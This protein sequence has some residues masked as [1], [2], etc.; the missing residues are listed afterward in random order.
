VTKSPGSNPEDQRRVVTGVPVRDRSGLPADLPPGDETEKPVSRFVSRRTILKAV[1]LSA[2]IAFNP[3]RTALAAAAAGP[4]LNI[5]AHEDDDLLF[6]SPDLLHA[7]QGGGKVRTIFVTAGD[8]GSGTSYWTGRQNGM[9]AA[10][11]Q[12]AGVSNSWTQADAGIAGHPMPLYT[13]S[14]ASAV[15]LIFMH[16]PDG[17]VDGGGFSSNNDE[18]LQELWQG[19]ISTI[20]AIDGSSSYTKA[21]LTSTLTA[22][23]SAFGAASVNTQD[24]VGTFG[25]GDHSDHHAAAYFAQA[26]QQAYG[27]SSVLAGYLDYGTVDKPANVTGAD[28]TAK[29]NA[30]Y[31]YAPYDTDQC[32]TPSACAG[33]DYPDWLQRQYLVT[34]STA[35]VA[36]AGSNQTVQPGATVTLNGSGSSDPNRKTLTYQ[37]TQTGGTAVTL[38]SSTAVQPTFTAPSSPGTLTFQLVVSNGTSSSSPATVAI[39]VGTTS[40]DL[41]LTAKATASSAASGQAAAKAIDGV[42]SGYPADSSKEWATNGGKAGSWLKLTWTTAQTIDTIVLY[43]RPNTSDQ[44]TGGNIAFSDG[45]SVAVGSLPNDGSAY[46]LTFAAKTVTTLQLNIT[47]VSSTTENVGLAEIQVYRTGSSGGSQPPVAN[48]GSN[49]TVQTGA[50]VTLNGTGSSDPGGKSLTYQ[51]TQTGGAAVTLS[52]STAAQPTFTA[53]SSA[54]TLTF[55]LVVNNGT[56]SSSP[57]TVTITVST[58]APSDLALTAKATASSAAS[59]QGAAKA[60]DGVISGYPADSSK[61]W[62]SNGGKAGSWL[63]LT[64][65]TAQTFNTIVLYDRPNTNDQITGGNI[66]FSDGTSIAVGSLPNAGTAYT[67]TF[68][69]KTVTTLQLNITSV[70]STTE[71]VGLSEI[72]VYFR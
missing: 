33:S 40:P 47:S 15:S 7:I 19:S 23:M 61:E 52:S 25:D 20:H 53:P 48:A 21:T 38:S 1:P 2:L 56:A 6:L 32:D 31:T 43:D 35:P 26:A 22:M 59:G 60:I 27:G 36:N 63:K 34:P 71:N 30:F 50:T 8:A 29:S 72:Q 37:W 57:A 45:S 12:M 18:S 4:T 28:L 46:T 64:W 62:A 54:A 13:L 70:S 65:T 55:Q 41:A 67:L 3:V 16:L 10:Y 11:A 39:T 44:I 58:A 42:I 5:V 17:D 69:A 49:Q 24:F 51:W 9:L 14:A 68:P 66:A